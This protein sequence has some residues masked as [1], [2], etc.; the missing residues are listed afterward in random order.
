MLA[1]SSQLHRSAVINSAVP[2]PRPPCSPL[3]DPSVR[4]PGKNSS[5]AEYGTEIDGDPLSHSGRI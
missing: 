2:L 5:G 1:K 3:Q 4:I